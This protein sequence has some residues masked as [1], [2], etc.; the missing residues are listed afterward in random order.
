M[1][2]KEAAKPLTQK[3]ISTTATWFFTVAAGISNTKEPLIAGQNKSLSYA[4]P[5]SF[6]TGQGGSNADFTVRKSTPGFS[7]AL[8]AE[9][10]INIGK[11]WK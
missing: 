4:S 6:L 8:G 7:Y 2:E 5:N 3:K 9:R 11:K 1:P 10:I